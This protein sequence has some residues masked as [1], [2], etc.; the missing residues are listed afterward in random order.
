M[1]S[2]NDPELLRLLDD[3]H[4]MYAA[5]DDALTELFSGD[6]SGF[7]GGGDFLV[8]DRAEWIAITRQDFAQVTQPLWLELEDSTIQ[9][10]AETIAVAT[11]FFKIHLP[12][13]D[14]FLSRRMARLVLVFRREPF[15]WKIAHSSISLPELSVREGEIY[16]MQDLL[17]RNQVLENRVAE[18]TALLADRNELLRQAN[19]A[20]SKEVFEHRQA[21]ASLAASEERL[22]SALAG[23]QQVVWERDPRSSGRTVGPEWPEVTGLT[24]E[25]GRDVDRWFAA[26]H[27]DDRARVRAAEER[28][29]HG[30]A[31][32]YEEECRVEQPDG[33]WRWL[34]V[35][36][37]LVPADGQGRSAQA[38]G[39]MM[40]VTSIRA[41]QARAASAERLAATTTL[42]RGMAHEINNPLASVLSNVYYARKQLEAAAAPPASTEEAVDATAVLTDVAQALSD[43]AE[44]AVRIRDI[45]A[46]LRCIALGE[47]PRGPVSSAL[48]DGVRDAQRIAAQDLA[49]CT[50][51]RVDVPQ[52]SDLTIGHSDIGQMVAHLLINAGQATGGKPNH[53]RL[54]GVLRDGH[55]ELRVSDTGTGMSEATLERAFEPFFTTKEVGKGRGLGLSVC[56]GIVEAA[57]GEIRLASQLGAGT[58][59]TVVLPRNGAGAGAGAGAG[60]HGSAVSREP[61]RGHLG[62]G[63]G[64]GTTSQPLGAH[65]R[66]G[67][68]P[69][70][71]YEREAFEKLGEN[72]SAGSWMI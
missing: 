31:G 70:A 21:E 8:K 42:A 5:R 6:F 41:L 24:F 60:R 1:S 29:L 2:S 72:P 40:D 12:I 71:G 53:V 28:C 61:R 45:V 48:A 50:S 55:V 64:E 35:A 56:L 4:R 52:V 26:V 37:R 30:R 11:S 58:T 18:Q 14:H 49:R 63:A 62:H 7:T 16:P 33:G 13:K 57:G 46:D 9:S 59:V 27:P 47:I 67:G 19:E 66:L 36:G 20:L 39:V 32:T 65:L 38:L 10:L 15:G 22:R 43:A 3:Y 25:Q 23:T 69:P 44:S 34:R 68:H 54:K 51:V 17:D